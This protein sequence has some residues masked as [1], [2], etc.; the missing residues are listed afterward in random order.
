MKEI[1]EK[2]EVSR[3]LFIIFGSGEVTLPDKVQRLEYG[4]VSLE[5]TMRDIYAASDILLCPSLY[6]SFG[7]IA[8]ESMICGTPVIAFERTGPAEIIERAKGG[9]VAIHNDA[10]SFFVKLKNI[11]AR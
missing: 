5:S 10:A 2:S 9:S 1:P 11:W 7:K 8:L 4:F 3:S 6:E